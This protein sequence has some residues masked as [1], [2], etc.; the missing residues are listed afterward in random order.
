[1][2]A[3]LLL[4]LSLPFLATWAYSKW[5][6]TGYCVVLAAVLLYF[7]LCAAA[8]A[9]VDNPAKFDGVHV[10]HR[11]PKLS[12][13][14][15]CTSVGRDDSKTTRAIPSDG[16]HRIPGVKRCTL[17]RDLYEYHHGLT[18]KPRALRG[19]IGCKLYAIDAAYHRN[20]ASLGLPD[21]LQEAAER[22]LTSMGLTPSD[23]GHVA[24]TA[25]PQ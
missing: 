2:I 23:I 15:E 3:V 12:N 11:C 7:G 13:P 1:M 25:S 8:Q 5:G 10:V 21:T 20:V 17:D 4:V 19:Y 22:V 16:Q 6:W 18:G 14:I 9:G 24:L